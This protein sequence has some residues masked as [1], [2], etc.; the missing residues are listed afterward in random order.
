MNFYILVEGKRTEA[1]VYPAWFSI[2]LSKY[3]RVQNFQNISDNSYYLFSANGYP[4]I[5]QTHF[6]N[7]VKDLKKVSKFEYLVLA[8]DAGDYGYEKR[9]EEVLS[10]AKK[11]NLLDESY[12]LIILVQNVCL[13][14]WFL[15][16][17]K[18]ISRNPS[19]EDY[20]KYLE[21]YNILMNDPEKMQKPNDYE[22]SIDNFHL[23]YL[24][25]VFQEKNISYNKNHPGE[26]RKKHYLDELRKR[27][28]KDPDH[29]KSFQKF[30]EFCNE[31][32]K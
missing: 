22:G 30:L 5:I 26:V 8:L 10:F 21:Y 12:K 11:N 9:Y 32:N 29:L 7:A 23:E 1:K 4:S 3:K 28:Q 17:R 14:T 18:M 31:A 15:G 19:D 27:I 20:K 25:K 24:K 13:E 2:L 6:P 16:N